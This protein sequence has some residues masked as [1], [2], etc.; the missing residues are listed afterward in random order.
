[1]ALSLFTDDF[2]EL[3]RDAI[4]KLVAEGRAES[5]VLEFKRGLSVAKKNTDAWLEGRVSDRARNEILEEVVAFANAAGG[6]LLLGIEETKDMPPRASSLAPISRCH[7]LA[8]RVSKF[9]QSCVEPPMLAFV[10]ARETGT[11]ARGVV[12]VHAP[13]SLLAPHRVIPTLQATIRRRDRCEKMTMREI[14]DLVLQRDRGFERISSAFD[15]RRSA[16]EQA[17]QQVAIETSV[18]C[19]GIRV[20]A[21]PMSPVR[22]PRLA[23]RHDLK[24]STDSF[25]A[26]YGESQ[27]SLH[28]N[29]LGNR[30][31]IFGGIQQRYDSKDF[32]TAVTVTN[33]GVIDFTQLDIRLEREGQVLYPG[34]VHAIAMKVVLTAVEFRRIVGLPALEYA[35]EVECYAAN[36]VLRWGGFEGPHYSGQVMN[37]N[38]LVLPRYTFAT[39]DEA[40]E[41]LGSVNQDL[42]NSAG[43]DAS[44]IKFVPHFPSVEG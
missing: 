34:W 13:A 28:I 38:P 12:G 7:E 42:M 16:F 33:D 23:G 26:S 19:Q 22:G 20:T 2:A 6:T 8:D 30:R 32:R 10:A 15:D 11:D 24:I 17:L 31:P 18:F 25:T 1:M 39:I 44:G 21:V 4:E 3:R 29:F 41:M 14:H 43:L 5:E 37:P 36:G 27:V 9:I 35:L 40:I